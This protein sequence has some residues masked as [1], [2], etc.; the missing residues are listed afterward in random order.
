MW[1]PFRKP[2]VRRC[3]AKEDGIPCQ[4]WGSPE[5]LIKA[6]FVV[7]IPHKPDK[8]VCDMH[9]REELL[10]TYL[11]EKVD[12]ALSEFALW[13]QAPPQMF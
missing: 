3:A 9:V 1:N 11:K 5:H 4:F 10:K 13:A 8:Y 2:L 7:S 12:A 6:T